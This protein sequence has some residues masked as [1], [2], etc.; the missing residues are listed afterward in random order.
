[1]RIISRRTLV[2]FAAREPT[3][4]EP[5]RYWHRVTRKSKWRTFAEVRTTF[6]ATDLVK[7]AGGTVLVFDIGGNKF[8]LV[9]HV[10]YQ[11]GKVY[12][13]RIMTHKEY[14]KDTWKDQL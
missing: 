11:K 4:D 1:M 13:L 3:A 2:Q 7:A 8:R 9:T 12:I 14:D 5:L 6:R 10:S